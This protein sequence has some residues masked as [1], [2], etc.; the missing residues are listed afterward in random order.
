MGLVHSNRPRPVPK[1]EQLKTLR[2]QQNLQNQPGS[3]LD[4][5]GG[6]H[7]KLYYVPGMPPDQSR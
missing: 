2:A 5:I 1:T 3:H 4:P 7:N 6:L